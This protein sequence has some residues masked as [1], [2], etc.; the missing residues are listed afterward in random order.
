MS[1]GFVPYLAM[2]CAIALKSPF[3]IL[4]LALVAPFVLY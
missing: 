2:I 3:T 4:N 1:L